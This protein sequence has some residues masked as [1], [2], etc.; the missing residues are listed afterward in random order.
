MD[1][2][3]VRTLDGLELSDAARGVWDVLAARLTPTLQG[4]D[5]APLLAAAEQAAR[6]V[7]L[8]R[9]ASI[10]DLLEGYTLGCEALGQAMDAHADESVRHAANRLAQLQPRLLRCLA[11]GYA[12]GL[13]DTIARLKRQAAAASP[14]DDCTGAMKPQQ[15]ADRLALEVLRCQRMDLS[16]GVAEMGV[17]VAG[18]EGGVCRRDDLTETQR[19]VGECLRES[20]RRYDSIGLTRGGCFLLVLPHVT[21]RGLAAAGE[22]L[23]REIA[24]CSGEEL[25]LVLALAHYDYVDVGAPDMLAALQRSMDEARDQ[26]KTVTWAA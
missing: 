5:V 19:E 2:L 20:L 13:E 23:R 6:G 17:E 25:R 11:A 15:I 18:D 4:A 8:S 21:R 12:A 26:G 10:G 14:V 24:G 3:I 7:G 22:R 1:A 9:E 16:L